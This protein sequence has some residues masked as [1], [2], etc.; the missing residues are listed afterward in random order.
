MEEVDVHMSRNFVHISLVSTSKIQTVIGFIFA[1]PL[2]LDP[3][4]ESEK[5]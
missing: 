1:N 3:S 4:I 2:S 5:G